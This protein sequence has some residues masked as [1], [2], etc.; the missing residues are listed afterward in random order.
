MTFS[1][2]IENLFFRLIDTWRKPCLFTILAITLIMVFFTLRIPIES[3]NASMV[4]RNQHLQVNYDLF[5]RTFGNDEMLLVA[6]TRPD[7]LQPEGLR[8]VDR[9]TSEITRIKGITRVLSLTNAMQLVPGDFGAETTLLIDKPYTG[10]SLQN[11]SRSLEQNPEL[12][13]LLLSKDRQ[14][15]VILIDLAGEAQQQGSGIAAIEVLLNSRFSDQNVHLTGIPLLKL[16]VSR[17]IQRDQRVIIPWSVAVLSVLLLLMF[18]RLSGLL[19]PLAAMAISLCWTVGLYSVCGNSL[20]T[21]TALLPPVI[22]VISIA[23]SVHL[24]SGWLHLAGEPGD[25]KRLLAGEMQKLFLPSLFAAITTALGLASLLVSDIPA[26]RL[27]AGYCAVGVML[28]WLINILVVPSALSFLPIPETGRRL[29]DIGVLKNL[30]RI[31]ANATVRHPRLV[32]VSM[33]L[34]AVAALSGLGRIENNTDLVRFLKPDATLRRDTLFI[35]AAFGGVNRVEFMLTRVDGRPL[36]TLDDMTRLSRLQ[37]SIQAVPHVS[38]SYSIISVLKQLGRAEL[39]LQSA[40]PESGNDLLKLFDLLEVAPDQEF[41]RKIISAD[42]TRLRLSVSTRAIGTADTAQLVSTIEKLAVSRLGNSYHVIPTGE[43][44]QLATDS[45]RLVASVASSFGLSLVMVF[46]PI[47]ILFRSVKL[48]FLVLLPNIIPLAWTAGLVAWL[49]IDLSTGTA[50]IASVAIG[51]TVDSTIYYLTRFL[52]EDRGDCKEAVIRTTMA[53][54]RA[55]TISTL[56]LFFGFSVGGLSSFMPTIYFSVLTGITM[57]G[58]LICDIFVLP[59][60]LVL[61]DEWQKRISI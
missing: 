47:F 58:A 52:R 14:T 44:Y 48:L 50:M 53:T 28:S 11:I 19:L 60:S 25:P 61:F 29:H 24:F 59:A 10:N 1:D 33:L 41:L 31:A 51:M 56:V 13:Q 12:S 2:I 21:I 20:N 46:I 30:L 18:R 8:T 34:T 35:D 57:M 9:L 55:L 22:M 39:K 5:R 27:F 3:N 54:G 49:G 37:D 6:I 15:G 16:T 17:L 4:S 23:T 45:N 36:T 40:L 42:F 38:G 7:L 26:V 43:S 32:L